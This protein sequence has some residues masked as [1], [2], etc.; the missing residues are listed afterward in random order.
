MSKFKIAMAAFAAS[1]AAAPVMAADAPEIVTVVKLTGINWFN[2]MEEGVKEFGASGEAVTSQTGPAQADAAQQL[3]II[4]DLVAK[5]VAAIAVVPNDPASLE[6]VLKRAIERGIKVVTHEADNQ[7]NTQYDVEAFE[8]PAYG[9]RLN[10]RLAECMQGEGKWAVFVGSLG[11]QTHNQWADGGIEN[12]KANN[13]KMELV[14][15][16]QESFNDPDKAYA[17]AQELLKKY[18]DIKGFQGSS[19]LDVIG[20]GRAIEEAGLQDKTCVY[21]TSLPSAAG[22]LLATGAIDGI[23]FWDPK[24]AGF[25]MNKVAK[26]LIDGK[27]VNDGDDLGVPGYN[28]VT[29]RQ[30]PGAGKIILGQAWADVDKT[31]MD[32][33]PF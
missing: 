33:Y 25:V 29:V 9:K 18:P 13:P 5:N 32:K 22:K 27:E 31:N 19:S 28:K 23:S 1:V 6:P 10:E 17:K 8:N 15:G 20:I 14:E 26:L 3:K 7:S 24:D 2:R 21:G 4:E 11:Q 30:G 16:K 12:A